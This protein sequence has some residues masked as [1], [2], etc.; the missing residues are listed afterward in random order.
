MALNLGDVPNMQRIA[1]PLSYAGNQNVDGLQAA[2]IYGKEFTTTVLK[3]LLDLIDPSRAKTNADAS[4]N[5]FLAPETKAG[6]MATGVAEIIDG[7]VVVRD[8]GIQNADGSWRLASGVAV[9]GA[10]GA[11]IGAVVNNQLN[12]MGDA[13]R[14]NCNLRRAA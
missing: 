14:D 5:G 8:Y 3:P 6:G 4:S 11:M 1:I 7:R 10:N 2:H 9:T 13:S 12:M